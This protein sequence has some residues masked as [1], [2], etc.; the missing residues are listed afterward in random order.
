[1]KVNGYEI[2]EEPTREEFATYFRVEAFFERE[3]VAGW[4][5]G[6]EGDGRLTEHEFDEL[7]YRYH[8]ADFSD[9]NSDYIG[10]EYDEIISERS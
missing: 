6:F 1:M 2:G 5:E 7:C 4:L 10:F 3:S 8:K 9:V